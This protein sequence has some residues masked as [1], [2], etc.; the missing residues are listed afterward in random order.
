MYIG[1]YRRHEAF[2]ITHT[3][4]THTMNTKE[5]TKDE[6]RNFNANYSYEYKWT[7]KK[8]VPNDGGKSNKWW[9]VFGADNKTQ[10]AYCEAKNDCDT[11][12]Y[13][14]K[15]LQGLGYDVTGFQRITK[16]EAE[17]FDNKLHLFYNVWGE[18]LSATIYKFTENDVTV[19]FGENVKTYKLDKSKTDFVY[20]ILKTKINTNGDSFKRHISNICEPTGAFNSFNMARIAFGI[21]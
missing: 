12:H 7:N 21:E 15:H 20:K 9:R 3:Q 16:E 19:Q 4:I 17:G 6:W 11:T 18:A 1:L 2:R 14:L 13:V 10:F 5:Q 8:L